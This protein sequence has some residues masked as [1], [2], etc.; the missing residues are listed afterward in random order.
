[1]SNIRFFKVRFQFMQLSFT[2]LVELNLSCCVR[3]CFSKSIANILKITS[4]REI[5]TVFSAVVH[6]ENRAHPALRS[7]NQAWQPCEDT[8]KQDIARLWPSEK[9]IRS[10]HLSQKT[11]PKKEITVWMYFGCLRPI[12]TLQGK[13][14][15]FKVS[16]WSIAKWHWNHDEAS[17][18]SGEVPVMD[19]RYAKRCRKSGHRQGQVSACAMPQLLRSFPGA[20]VGETRWFEPRPRAGRSSRSH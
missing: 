15:N 6:A 10:E 2:S 5:Q 7:A 12:I 19:S 16:K 11:Q 3:A 8:A 17:S 13:G 14:R 4:T 20:I 18:S 1:M 9:P